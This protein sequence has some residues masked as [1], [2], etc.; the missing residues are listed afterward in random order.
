MLEKLCSDASIKS[1]VGRHPVD[2]VKVDIESDDGS[3]LAKQYGVSLFKQSIRSDSSFIVLL[4]Q[5]LANY[6]RIER[7]TDC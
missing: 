3:L 7:R 5:C 4:G 6:L 2:L 1:G